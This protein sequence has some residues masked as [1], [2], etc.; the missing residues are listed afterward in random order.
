M[1]D[2]IKGIATKSANDGAV[3]VAESLGHTEENFAKLMTQQ[4][5]TL[6]RCRYQA[7]LG[8]NTVQTPQQKE[9]ISDVSPAS[10]TLCRAQW[11]RPYI[12]VTERSPVVKR[13]QY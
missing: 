7:Q 2:A 6:G 11:R 9:K 10:A 1:E 4:A 12:D 8:L 5:H 3:G 13:P